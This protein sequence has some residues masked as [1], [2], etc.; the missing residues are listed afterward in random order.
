MVQSNAIYNSFILALLPLIAHQSAA[1]PTK[2]ITTFRRRWQAKIWLSTESVKQQHV[3]TNIPPL[4]SPARSSFDKFDY[5]AHWYPVI[6]AQDLPLNEP[7]KV[8]VFDVDYVV[9]KTSDTQVYCLHDRCPH[10]AAALSQG[11]VTATG[12]FQCAYHG[13]SFSGETG[14]CVDIPQIATARNQKSEQKKI[15]SRSCAQAVPSQIFQGMVW[16]FPGGDWE[17]ALIAP[18]PP[19]VPEYDEP[20][21]KMTTAVREM[22]V[23]WPILV[24][25]ICDP[26]HGL[27]AHQNKAFD[28]YSASTEYPLEVTEDFPNDGRGY[29][30]KSR[31]DSSDKLLEVD[32]T[33]RRSSKANKKTKE[34]ETPWATSSLFL[35]NHLQ[36]KRVHKA[37]NTSS[38]VS[39]FY[40]CP[41]GVGRSRFMSA[42]ISRKPAPRWTIKLF[43]DNF[44]DQD[45]YLLATQQQYILGQ[46]AK[47]VQGMIGNSSSFDPSLKKM[48]T[49]RKLFCLCSPTERFGAKI[50]QF[51]DATLLKSPNRIPR[52]LQLH[53][54]GAF[55]STPSREYVLDR[56]TQHL[57]LV[58]DSQDVVRNCKRISA[59]SKLVLISAFAKFILN[60]GRRFGTRGNALLLLASGASILASWLANRVEREYYFKYTD[61][62]RR[63]DMD[64]IPQN[65]W[66]DK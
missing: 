7:T 33:W 11:R 30:I 2:P 9:A 65:I 37:A 64:S 66:V 63:K 32:Q 22:P 58:R 56:K 31:V 48:N 3:S 21:F 24:S 39:A 1:F 51:W 44:L 12:K 18:P 10:K 38:F 42:A 60:N 59:G 29:V 53:S 36:L 45:T 19:S 40:I 4:A 20:G 25:N 27:F 57:D 49:R 41:V 15:P 8:T 50:E 52:L 43:L 28:M 61:E 17:D 55:A 5:N 14:E 26:D 35:P 62:M 23:D 34:E 16:V 47:D 13:W 54:S 46:E 6:W